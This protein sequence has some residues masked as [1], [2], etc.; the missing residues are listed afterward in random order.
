M[1]EGAAG[2]GV[3][4]AGRGDQDGR[5]QAGG[6][7]DDAALASHDLL[8]CVDALAPRGDTGGGSD[9]PAV[10]QAGAGLETGAFD[11]AVGGDLWGPDTWGLLAA[12]CHTGSMLDLIGGIGTANTV[13]VCVTVAMDRLPWLRRL[14]TPVI[15]VGTMSGTLYMGH[16]LVFLALPDEAATPPRS[17]SA[18]TGHCLVPVADLD[19][20]RRRLALRRSRPAS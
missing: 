20:V 4:D 3:L 18:G 17:A 9:A 7:G 13:L 5:Q 19:V 15:T 16:I 6:V 10:D 11:V 14:A 8:A 12:T 2:G 1:K